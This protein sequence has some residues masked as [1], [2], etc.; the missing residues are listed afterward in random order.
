MKATAILFS[1]FAAF[2][3]ASPAAAEMIGGVDDAP[4]FCVVPTGGTNSVADSDC[5][6]CDGYSKCSKPDGTTYSKCGKTSE[7]KCTGAATDIDGDTYK[8]T[9]GGDEE[10]EKLDTFLG[11]LEKVH[12]ACGCL[13]YSN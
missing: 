6:A 7:A 3:L 12:Y 1:L 11:G 8:S 10:S 5:E 9:C 13:T 4:A 2:V